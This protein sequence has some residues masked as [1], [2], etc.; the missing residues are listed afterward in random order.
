[1][2]VWLRS[3]GWQDFVKVCIDCSF[4]GMLSLVFGMTTGSDA[5]HRGLSHAETARLTL[6]HFELPLPETMLSELHELLWSDE[7]EGCLL[8]GP[9]LGLLL[10]RWALTQPR[11]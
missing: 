8:S 10:D 11:A 3:C 5:I 9:V 7:L 6:A 1:M 4:D 2:I